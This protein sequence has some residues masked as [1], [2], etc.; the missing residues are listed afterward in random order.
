M[1]YFYKYASLKIQVDC[2]F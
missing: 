1:L 2:S